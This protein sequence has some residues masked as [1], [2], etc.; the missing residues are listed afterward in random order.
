MILQEMK[1]SST[2][3]IVVRNLFTTCISMLLHLNAFGAIRIGIAACVNRRPLRVVGCRMCGQKCII[4]TLEEAT[5]RSIRR[6]SSKLN[7]L[8]RNNKNLSS[9]TTRRVTQNIAKAGRMHCGMEGRGGGKRKVNYYVVGISRTNTN[10]ERERERSHV[11]HPINHQVIAVIGDC[12]ASDHI[13]AQHSQG[14]IQ[15]RTR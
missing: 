6:P 3:N 5:K 11:T 10:R 9:E 13:V 2:W 1:A 8:T 14:N 12:Q 4:G 7:Q 15:R